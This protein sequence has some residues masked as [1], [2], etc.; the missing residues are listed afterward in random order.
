MKKKIVAGLFAAG[1]VVAGGAGYYV[2]N[3]KMSEQSPVSLSNTQ[4]TPMMNTTNTQ[5]LQQLV[6]KPNQNQNQDSNST[7]EQ[8][9]PFMKKMHPNLSDKELKDLF[10]SMHGKNGSPSCNPQAMMGNFNGGTQ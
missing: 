9:L 2:G 6:Q 7:F 4:V 5:G 1:L 8:M 10:D 3:T